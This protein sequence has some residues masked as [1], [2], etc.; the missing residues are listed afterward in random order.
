MELPPALLQLIESSE[1][2]KYHFLNMTDINM[3][4]L[5]IKSSPTGAAI[6]NTANQSFLLRTVDQ[7]NSLMFFLP[8][9]SDGFELVHTAKQYFELTPN[10]T[11]IKL[12]HLLP[13][14]NGLE[15]LVRMICKR[16]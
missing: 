11:K 1:C 4:R 6:L 2:R 12:N 14:Y 7:S 5:T 13:E 16:R 8:T 3:H 10:P 9:E 15:V